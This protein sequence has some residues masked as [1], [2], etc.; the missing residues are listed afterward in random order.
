MV[1]Q[2]LQTEYQRRLIDLSITVLFL[3]SPFTAP[4]ISSSG[5]LFLIHSLLFQQ[6][7][8]RLRRKIFYVCA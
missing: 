5:I 8:P 6:R 2:A 3:I 7:F 4:T 1:R